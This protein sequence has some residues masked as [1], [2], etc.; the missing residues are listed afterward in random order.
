MSKAKKEPRQPDP[1]RSA[2]LRKRL[3]ADLTG[4]GRREYQEPEPAGYEPE[5]AEE[6]RQELIAELDELIERLKQQDPQYEPPPFSTG[7]LLD[8]LRER[9]SELPDDL[10]LSVLQKLR[11]AIREDVFDIDTWKGLWYMLNYELEFRSDQVKRRFT[12][13]YETDPWGLDWEFL[14]AVRPFAEFV[15]RR[16]FRAQTSGIENIPEEG[17]ALLVVNHSGQLPFDGA[18]VAAAV[19]LEHPAER[20]VRTLYATW[21]PTLPFLSDLFQ[22]TGQVLATVENGIRLLEQDEL[23]S[24]FPEGYKGVG[25]LYKER[26]RLARFGRGGFIK[27]ALRT[28]APII[29]VSVVGAEETYVSIYKS[30]VLAKLTGFPYFPIS[31]RFP[32]LGLLGMVPYPTK[33]Y[34]DF[35]EPIPMDEYGEAA[36]ENLVLVNRLTEEV[37]GEIQ[38]MI[39]ERLEKRQSVFFG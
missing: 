13:D 7:R 24:V 4:D 17:R 32:W 33:W 29:P 15:Y 37:R 18:M 10:Q 16:Y 6:L 23:V 36:A 22:R 3:A 12:G 11:G 38:H 14:D 9:G 27:M 39:Y 26:Y 8:L 28:Q 21:F 20:L 35:G 1:D 34:I 2:D 19:Q 25:K 30:P 31:L 5:D